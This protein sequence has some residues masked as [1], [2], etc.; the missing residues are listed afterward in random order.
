[1]KVMSGFHIHKPYFVESKKFS[2]ACDWIFDT[3]LLY[4]EYFTLVLLYLEMYI[5]KQRY[6]NNYVRVGTFIIIYIIRIV[7]P[8]KA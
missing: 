2:R 5:Y 3:K 1:M 8:C 6:R 4:S 7:E